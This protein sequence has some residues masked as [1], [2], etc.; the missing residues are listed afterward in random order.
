MS[1]W[2]SK[3][4]TANA[5]RNLVDVGDSASVVDERAGILVLE[6]LIARHSQKD[7]GECGT[8]AGV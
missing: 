8:G 5:A 4:I 3:N 7:L 1:A 2:S 6:E